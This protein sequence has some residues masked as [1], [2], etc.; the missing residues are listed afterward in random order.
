MQRGL[1]D[2]IEKSPSDFNFMVSMQRGL[3][4]WDLQAKGNSNWWSQCKEDWKPIL[5]WRVV[6]ADKTMSQCKED[7]KVWLINWDYLNILSQRLN[8]KRIESLLI[9]VLE[10]PY[11]QYVSM[12][13]GLKDDT[14]FD[15]ELTKPVKSQCKEDWKARAFIVSATAVIGSL[16]AKRIERSHEPPLIDLCGYVWSQC[17]EDWKIITPYVTGWGTYGLNAKRIE[18]CLPV[19]RQLHQSLCLNAKR[20]ERQFSLST[21]FLYLYSSQCKEDWKER[22]THFHLLS[23]HISLNAK[24]IERLSSPLSP[25]PPSLSSQCKEDWK[26]ILRREEKQGR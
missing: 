26:A 12:Q 2:L 17:K 5:R 1:K 3:K 25:P 6:P 7:W 24:R 13:R 9:V 4:G 21:I 10:N 8:A 22:E 19:V 16:N 11:M 18:R 15:T 23:F 14:M 20:I